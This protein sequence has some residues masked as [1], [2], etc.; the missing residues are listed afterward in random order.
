MVGEIIIAIVVVKE[1]GGVNVDVIAVIF[2]VDGENWFVKPILW[3]CNL[4]G[5]L[6]LIVVKQD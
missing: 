5:I 4:R 6:V 2:M 1:L 3:I